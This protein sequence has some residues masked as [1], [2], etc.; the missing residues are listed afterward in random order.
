MLDFSNQTCWVYLARTI[1]AILS[2]PGVVNATGVTLNGDMA[3]LLLVETGEKQQVPVLGEV[4]LH[5]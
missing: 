4:V 3:D 2:V 1:S 5:A